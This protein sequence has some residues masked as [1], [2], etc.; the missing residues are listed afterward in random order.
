MHLAELKGVAKTIPNEGILISTLSLQEAQSNSEIESI[1]TTQDALYKQEL[2]ASV[3]DPDVRA[4]ELASE[5][6]QEQCLKMTKQAMLFLSR[7]LQN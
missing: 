2:Q 6:P 3:S 5:K 4:T 7:R 1:I